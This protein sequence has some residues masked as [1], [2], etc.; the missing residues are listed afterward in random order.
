MNLPKEISREEVFKKYGR[1]IDK[2]MLEM[3]DGRQVDFYLRRDGHPVVVLAL[4]SE[5]KVILFKQFRPGPGCLLAEM[6]GGMMEKNET[7][8]QAI[9]RELLEETGYKGEIEFVTRCWDCAYTDMH[10]YCFVAR[11]CKKVC[12]PQHNENENGEVMEVSLDEFRNIL[13]QGEM[14]DVEA[15]YLGLDYLKLL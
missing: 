10:R 2:V 15:G 11:D 8:E 14:T 4:T 13:R 9:A 3:P 6:P 5:N 1:A 12:E 7:P